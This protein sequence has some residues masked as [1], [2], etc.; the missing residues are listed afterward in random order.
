MKQLYFILSI[1]FC[2]L[3]LLFLYLHF[4][5]IP[6]EVDK[7]IHE[8]TVSLIKTAQK[9][10]KGNTNIKNVIKDKTSP[11][12][13]IWEDNLFDPL[14]GNLAGIVTTTKPSPQISDMELIGVCNTSILQGAII[15]QAQ[16]SYSF[17]KS[18][19]KNISQQSQQKRFFKVDERLPNGY[20]LE[21]VNTDSVTLK[22]GNEQITL[23]LKFDDN[24]S[25]SRVSSDA[26]NSVKAQLKK[27]REQKNL[28]LQKNKQ[29]TSVKVTPIEKNDKSTEN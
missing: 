28:L 9:T 2:L 24:D 22:R 17:K 27:I 14:R 8:R 20:T 25:G 15:L 18:K 21:E 19:N 23:K 5:Y 12:A 4:T 29:K 16:K 1:I 26:A 7:K 11:P 3:I 10:Y 6:L 13:D